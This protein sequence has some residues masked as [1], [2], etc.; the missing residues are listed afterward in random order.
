METTNVIFNKIPSNN[1]MKNKTTKSKKTIKSRNP[2][3]HFVHF[4]WK[5][6]NNLSF[7]AG[8]KKCAETWKTMDG[9]NKLIFIKK[10]KRCEKKNWSKKSKKTKSK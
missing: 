4:F 2:Y 7:T 8:T 1:L 9:Q 5:K 6:N 10:A 3:H